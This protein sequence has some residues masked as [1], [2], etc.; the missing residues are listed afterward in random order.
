[1]LTLI[2]VTFFKLPIRKIDY[3]G[4]FE[5]PFFRKTYREKR[6]RQTAARR[7]KSLV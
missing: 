1:M 7:D 2:R 6:D 5:P 3:A 4:D